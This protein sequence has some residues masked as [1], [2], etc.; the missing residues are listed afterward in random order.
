VQGKS[1]AATPIGVTL[2]GQF[3]QT[4][5]ASEFSH[6]WFKIRTD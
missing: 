1:S 6:N 3:A 4:I 5:V 2:I